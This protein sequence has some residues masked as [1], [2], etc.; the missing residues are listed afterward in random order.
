MECAC[1]W[2]SGF[3]QRW[4]RGRLCVPERGLELSTSTPDTPGRFSGGERRREFRTGESFYQSCILTHFG[5][6]SKNLK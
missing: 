5:F 6:V 1:F 3:F 2:F 4:K